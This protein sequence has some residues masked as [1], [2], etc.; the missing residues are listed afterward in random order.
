MC[1]Y[2]VTT[3]IKSNLHHTI[4][5]CVNGEQLAQNVAVTRWTSSRVAVSPEEGI[6]ILRDKVTMAGRRD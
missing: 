6:P 1:I 4:N 2:Y 5:S 3:C